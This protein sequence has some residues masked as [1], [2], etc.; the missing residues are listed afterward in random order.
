MPFSGALSSKSKEDLKD[1]AWALSLA[2]NAKATKADIQRDITEHLDH[3][4]H[5][6]ENPRFSRLYTSH[7]KP[8]RAAPD[9]EN[10]APPPSSSQHFGGGDSYSIPSSPPPSVSGPMASFSN[11]AISRSPT[12]SPL[13]FNYTI[14]PPHLT[15]VFDNQIPFQTFPPVISHEEKVQLLHNV[16]IP[17]S[18]FYSHTE[19]HNPSHFSYT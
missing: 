11:S 3:F 1:I 16:P 5:L 19:T 9:G 17:S 14:I 18:S 15:S 8:K 10:L 6:A 12:K 7:S 2:V 4:P 13:S